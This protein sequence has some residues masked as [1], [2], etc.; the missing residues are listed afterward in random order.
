MTASD[1]AATDPLAWLT[2]TLTTATL[3]GHYRVPAE[4]LLELGGRVR[5]L[6][7][8]LDQAHTEWG[9]RLADAVGESARRGAQIAELQDALHAARTREA[10]VRP[11]L[12]A[13]LLWESAPPGTSSARHC[14]IV[15][16]L[17]LAAYRG[18]LDGPASAGASRP[19]PVDPEC[20]PD[21]DHLKPAALVVHDALCSCTRGPV[22]DRENGVMVARALEEAGMLASAH[23]PDPAALL[24][25]AAAGR[26]EY[27]VNAPDDM[28]EAL[29][30]QAGT[31]EHAAQLVDGDYRPLYNW[32][33]SWRWTPEMAR[34]VQKYDS[35]STTWAEVAA[36]AEAAP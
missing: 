23:A 31:I 24:R 21:A 33:P 16:E 19:E 25:A 1:E 15:L 12:D 29:D 32:L 10:I 27:A 20:K 5:S 9:A 13:A 30:S 11:V 22:C 34:R 18:P 35:A 6:Q 8:E 3:D 14:D 26:R 17:A 4:R 36:I 2:V 28:A 7:L